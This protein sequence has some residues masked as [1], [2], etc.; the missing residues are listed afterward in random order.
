MIPDGSNTATITAAIVDDSEPEIDESFSVTLTSV[1]LLNY[2][3]GGRDFTYPGDDSLIDSL[4]TISD[5]SDM[6]QATIASNDDAF[7]VISLKTN[8]YQVNEGTTLLVDV[9][10]SGGTFGT[11]NL[12]FT[13][14]S[15]TALGNG[16]DYS[17]PTS[18]I[19][20]LPGQSLLQLTI[21]IIDDIT[22]EL[23]E[24]FTVT[25]DSVEGGASLGTI[26]TATV[27]I[28][29]S[30]NPNGRVRFTD[31]DV[32][33]RV[34]AN[35]AN[36]PSDIMLEVLRLDGSIGSIDVSSYCIYSSICV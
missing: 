3:N 32:S 29:P 17:A 22:P 35:P 10:R 23:Q 19:N 24:S 11:L 36:S 33:G 12:Q 14:Q 28:L 6:F 13:V 5:S 20:I 16:I 15:V 9:E 8:S 18:P 26:R 34:V 31:S 2:N 1:T 25:I 4:P 30:D 21:P 27:I 7:G